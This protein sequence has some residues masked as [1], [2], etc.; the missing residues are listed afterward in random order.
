MSENARY[1]NEARYAALIEGTQRARSRVTPST[2]PHRDAAEAVLYLEAR[3]LDDGRYEEWLELL[4]GD[5]LYW[6]PAEAK[7]GDPRHEACVNFD[8]R[9][10]LLDRVALLRTGYL[11]AQT[12]PS[13]TSRTIG[14][15]E[16]WEVQGGALEVRS[17]LT[18]W[19]YRQGETTPYAGAQEHE[20]VQVKGAWRI[21]QKTVRLLNSDA[22]LGNI[23][24]I[25]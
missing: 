15:V 7:R 12:P 16:T 3:L 21:R 24:F 19:M 17:S 25:L 2:F 20:L 23:T 22:P 8:D 14:N 10:R 11:H 5:C 6:V 13:R 18:L 9:R 1:L 4:T